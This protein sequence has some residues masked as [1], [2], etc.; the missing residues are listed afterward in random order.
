L[1]KFVVKDTVSCRAETNATQVYLSTNSVLINH[2]KIV[3]V[4]SIE[5]VVWYNLFDAAFATDE[6]MTYIVQF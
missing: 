1:V 3:P 4:I 2:S 6:R 5:F